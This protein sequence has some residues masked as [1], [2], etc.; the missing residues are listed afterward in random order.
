[1]RDAKSAKDAEVHCASCS[2]RI[3]DGNFNNTGMHEYDG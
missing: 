2:T 3:L 1:M